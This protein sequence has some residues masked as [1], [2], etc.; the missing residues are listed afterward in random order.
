MTDIAFGILG[1]TAMR[2][3]GNLTV[4]GKPRERQLLAVL[5]AHPVQWLPISTLTEWIWPDHTVPDNPA[6]ALHT[7]ATRLRKAL[8]HA[9][10]HAKLPRA[11]RAYFIEVDRNL[12]DYH[13]FRQHVANARKAF[14]AGR[15]EHAHS[16]I[17][18]ALKLWRGQPL[19]DLDTELAARWRQ[20]IIRR[21]WIPAVCL[22]IDTEIRLG[23]SDRALELFAELPESFS[24]NLDLA[25]RRIQVLYNL[26]REEDAVG[27]FLAT[28]QRLRRHSQDEA[29]EL[30]KFHDRARQ[31]AEDQPPFARISVPT[32][33]QEVPR[34]APHDVPGFTGR[35]DILNQLDELTG[36]ATDDIR[37]RAIVLAGF[38][39]V[40]KTTTAVHWAHRAERHFSAG[41]FFAD[42]RGNSPTHRMDTA[43]LVDTFLAA[44]DPSTD[45]SSGIAGRVEKLRAHLAQGTALIILDNAADA[46]HIQPMLPIFARCVVLITSRRRLDSIGRRHGTPPLV[47]P[48]LDDSQATALLTAKLRH[49]AE[50]EP[51]A[52]ADLAR[53]CGGVPLALTLVADRAARS[54]SAPL[55]HVT[56]QLSNRELLLRIGD[57]GD[58]VD[59]SLH[60]VFTNSYRHLDL[61]DATMFRVLGLHP[62]TEFSTELAIAL[63]GEPSAEVTRR[64][65]RLVTAHMLGQPGELD[66][67]RMH[68]LLH[69]FASTLPKAGTETVAAQSRMLSFYLTSA[70]NAH[71]TVF[72]HRVAPEILPLAP[73]CAPAVFHDDQDAMRWSLRE[74]ANLLAVTI[75]AERIGRHE[76]AWR[77]PHAIAEILE[78]CG[79][80]DDAVHAL[81]TAATS[82][83]TIDERSAYASSLND[84]GHLALTRGDPDTASEHFRH[85]LRLAKE[86]DDPL[87]VLTTTLNLA[88]CQHHLGEPDRAIRLYEQCA[89]MAESLNDQD[90]RAGVAH[91]LGQVLIDKRHYPEAARQLRRALEIRERLGDRSGTLETLNELAALMRDR[92]DQQQAEHYGRRALE[93]LDPEHDIPA[94]VRA[95]TMMA[96]LELDK[97]N[98]PRVIQLADAAIQ[99]A[100]QTGDDPA[101]AHALNLLGA[102]AYA[103]AEHD[104]ARDAW[105]RAAQVLH[106]ARGGLDLPQNEVAIPEQTPRVQDESVKITQPGHIQ[107]HQG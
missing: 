6:G 78:R 56:H 88:R 100:R 91:R 40:G 18:R 20:R 104:V 29:D 26:D 46:A 89:A 92:G 4:Q 35:D 27:D 54:P 2:M 70:H 21:D 102:A 67:Y 51:E 106:T 39:G 101:T 99:R 73:R 82:A 32:N 84:L 36:V 86:A 16:R 107:G 96:E 43:E 55:R 28:H 77:I 10:G 52:L 75:Y 42:L 37:P 72:P 105:S 23:H 76:Y 11:E 8:E 12:L 62:G 45:F 7:Y 81:E 14:H 80:Y 15:I 68:D 47:V 90:R 57:D 33:H 25:K 60:T 66:R 38:G 34:Q 87:G 65:D 3:H 63:A 19:A 69:A 22:K 50:H 98:F 58:G 59:E 1:K 5:L 74:S 103:Q 48:P 31:H 24:T 83:K 30:R 71:R 93:L 94:G 41:T 44:L 17:G 95:Y 9:G 97:R 64:L 79:Y 53:I 61:N 85:A 49:R 13:A